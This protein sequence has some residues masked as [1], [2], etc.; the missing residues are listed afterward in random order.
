M[1]QGTGSGFGRRSLLHGAA[2]SVG[3]V[4]PAVTGAVPAGAAPALVRRGRPRASWG[5]Q[6]GDE[7]GGSL[8]TKTLQPGW[9]GQ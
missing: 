1:A 9:V 7:G 4:P 8:F 3:L 6:A 2:G 5:V